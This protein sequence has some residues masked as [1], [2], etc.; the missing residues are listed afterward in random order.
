[1]SQA[2]TSLKKLWFGPGQD[3]LGQNQQVPVTVK[4]FFRNQLFCW[5][6]V[7]KAGFVRKIQ[8]MRVTDKEEA[9]A[10]HRFVHVTLPGH[11]RSVSL[12]NALQTH[13]FS[14]VVLWVTRHR[15]GFMKQRNKTR[16]SHAFVWTWTVPQ[17]WRLTVGH[18]YP[19]FQHS[20][21]K[22]K[23]IIYS[24]MQSRNYKMK[25]RQKARVQVSQAL[26]SPKY[27]TLIWKHSLHNFSADHQWMAA[28][29]GHTIRL[30]TFPVLSNWLVSTPECQLNND[31]TSPG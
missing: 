21:W 6:Y 19:K 29:T 4:L 18:H 15:L 26:A 25:T 27:H 11:S 24:N 7:C 16:V 3:F 10:Q 31:Q 14:L 20:A 13:W 28:E 22:T 2:R 5:P 9:A 17:R 30:G 1:M 12:N 8:L 23:N